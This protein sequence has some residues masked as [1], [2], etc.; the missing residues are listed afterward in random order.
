[1]GLLERLKLNKTKDFFE[2]LDLILKNEL[3]SEIKAINFNLYEDTDNKWSDK[4][5]KK[6]CK[7][8]G[9]DSFYNKKRSL[10]TGLILLITAFCALP[11]D[12]YK[13][14]PLPVI[15]MMIGILLHY[16]MIL[17]NVFCVIAKVIFGWALVMGYSL[18]LIHIFYFA[19]G[20]RTQ[21]RLHCSTNDD[22]SSAV[23]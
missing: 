18:S 13:R 11:S 19:T 1:M 5:M 21:T 20:S 15:F 9:M 23:V 10:L 3:N 16:R 17:Y 8:N 12:V 4:S 7:R 2:W 22:G 14:Q 6:E